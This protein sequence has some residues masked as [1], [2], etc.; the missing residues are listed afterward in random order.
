MGILSPEF[1]RLIEQ[2]KITHSQWVPTMFVRLLKL[3]IEQRN[4]YDL[5]SMKMAV[6]AAAP[7]PVDIKHQMIEWWGDIIHEYYAGTENNGF[8]SITSHEWLNHPGSVGQAKLGIPHICNE[9]GDELPIGLEGEVYFENGHQFIY[10]NDPQKTA[11][12]CNHH[13]WTTLGDIGRLDEEGYLYLTG[14]KSFLIISGGI[15][16][17]PQ[18]TENILL[19]H[20]MVLDAAVIGIPDEEFGESVQAVVQPVTPSKASEQLA[21]D[22][23]SYCRQ[24]LSPIKC[25]KGIDFRETLP[26]SATGKLYKRKLK[27]EYWS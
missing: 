17:Y 13:G 8:T 3:P 27:D 20:P 16:I 7:C 22:L 18:E 14:R 11:S 19:G 24:N 25:P 26:R 1:L 6:H 21:E 15:N 12:A 2:Y 5:S 23:I 10:H 9:A 4:Q